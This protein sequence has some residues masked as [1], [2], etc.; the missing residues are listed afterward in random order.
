MSPAGGFVPRN[1]CG[2]NKGRTS[3]IFTGWNLPSEPWTFIVDGEGLVYA[4]FE[5][6]ATGD[7]LE[8]APVGPFQ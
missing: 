8:K 5:G 1:E 2:T 6:F 7:E 4:K 3:L